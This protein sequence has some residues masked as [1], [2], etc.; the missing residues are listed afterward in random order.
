MYSGLKGFFCFF[1]LMLRLLEYFDQTSLAIF[2]F[3]E[4]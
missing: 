4:G 3:Q 1:C 2:E